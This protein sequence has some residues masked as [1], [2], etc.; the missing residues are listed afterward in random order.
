MHF[1]VCIILELM[2]KHTL[3][4]CL[5]WAFSPLGPTNQ[6]QPPHLVEEETKPLRGETPVPGDRASQWPNWE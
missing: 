4:H 3:R 2:L 1:S 5:P 6:V